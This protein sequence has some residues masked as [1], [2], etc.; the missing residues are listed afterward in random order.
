MSEMSTDEVS[1]SEEPACGK[2]DDRS[3]TGRTSSYEEVFALAY[4]AA[5]N[6]LRPGNGHRIPHLSWQD[7]ED[8]LQDAALK[9]WVRLS[10]GS[11]SPESEDH[12][13]NLL[14]RAARN[15]GIDAWRRETRNGR[16]NH[17]AFSFVEFLS[18]PDNQGFETDLA[19]FEVLD[20]LSFEERQLIFA[21]AVLQMSW[22]E[23]SRLTG[24]TE[25]AARTRFCRLKR[26]LAYALGAGQADHCGSHETW[27]RERIDLRKERGSKINREIK[28]L[29]R[30]NSGITRRTAARESRGGGTPSDYL[31]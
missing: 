8:F 7:E 2:A 14:R 18:R 4:R 9:I 25:Q 10:E 1:V 29:P 12:F 31:M 23:I 20:G 30:R 28:S 16:I 19:P 27:C 17:D 26:K 22:Q 6:G 5:K 3:A 11:M 21:R 13:V 24:V 15:A